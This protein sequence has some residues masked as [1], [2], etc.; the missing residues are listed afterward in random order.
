VWTIFA[1]APV[2]TCVWPRLTQSQQVSGE[3]LKFVL[4]LTRHGVRSPTWTNVR[5][6]DYSKDPWPKWSVAPGLLTPHGKALMT[7]FGAY[8]RASFAQDGLMPASGCSGADRV[9]IYADSDERTRETGHGI[10]DGMLPGCTVEVHS[11]LEGARDVLFHPLGAVGK[12]D[13]DLAFSAIAGRIGDDP[14]ALL[15]AYQTQL[16]QLQRVL[17]SCA[18]PPCS[19]EGKKSVLE[20]APSLQRGKGDHLADLRGPL[21]TGATFAENFQLEYLEGMPDAQIGWGRVDEAKMRELMAIHAA[22]SDLVQRA[23]YA[24]RVQASNLLIHILHTLEQAEV[25]R[26]VAGA[27]GNSNDKVVFLVGHDTNISNISAL[28]ELHW[29]IDGYQPDDAPP[30]GALVFELWRRPAHEDLVRAYYT[31][32]TPDQ[33]RHSTS[34]TLKSPPGKAPLFVPGCS[35]ALAGSPCDWS[36]FRRLALSAVDNAFVQ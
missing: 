30:G 12:P 35:Q 31:V 15:P 34:L 24:A 18:A 7:Q 25:Q 10:A 22:S 28:L 11:L 29:L 17:F 5:L 14:A 32:Q 33:M 27:I 13:A 6:D 26:A 19:G 9:Y 4:V 23:P 20:I 16:E 36:A 8:Y 2:L 3:R 1:A 21:S